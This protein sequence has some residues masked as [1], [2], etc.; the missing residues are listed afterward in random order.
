M[1]KWIPLGAFLSGLSVILG[2]FGAH[3]L[4][5]QLTEKKMAV[6]H[7]ATQYLYYHSLALIV[8]G[9]LAMQMGEQYSKKLNLCAGF[10][11]AGILLFCGSLYVLTFDGPRFFGPITPFGGLCFIIGWFTLAWTFLK[12]K[13]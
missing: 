7:T 8:V 10:F 5:A 3:S 13:V 4:K 12:K 11:A 2:A 9:V 1:K 6:F